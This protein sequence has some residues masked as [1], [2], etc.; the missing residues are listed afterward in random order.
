MQTAGARAVPIPYDLPAA[1]VERRHAPG[2]VLSRQQQ[3]TLGRTCHPPGCRRGGLLCQAL[4]YVSTGISESA[5]PAAREAPVVQVQGHQWRAHTWR[6][7]KP[8]P[9]APLLRHGRAASGSRAAGQRPGHIL[10]CEHPARSWSAMPSSCSW[11]RS[12]SCT[13]APPLDGSTGFRCLQQ[14]TVAAEKRRRAHISAVRSGLH[15]AK[16]RRSRAQRRLLDAQLE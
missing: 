16:C 15:R 5:L 2:R 9:Q 13:A 3:R 8:E 12:R 14:V 6:R 1:E 7:G 4:S 11:H 10:P